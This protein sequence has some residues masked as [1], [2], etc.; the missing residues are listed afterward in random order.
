[1]YPARHCVHGVLHGPILSEG[2]C[3]FGVQRGGKEG[4]GSEVHGVVGDIGI[5]RGECARGGFCE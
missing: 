5:G 3:W 2:F 4:A 1:M